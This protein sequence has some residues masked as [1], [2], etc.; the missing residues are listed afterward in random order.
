MLF[1]FYRTRFQQVAL[2]TR[3]G[4]LI[5]HISDQEDVWIGIGFS[6]EV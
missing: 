5:L 2:T 6:N 3:E 4:V 1:I